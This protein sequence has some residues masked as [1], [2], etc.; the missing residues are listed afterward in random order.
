MGEL[1]LGTAPRTR[2]V[3][4]SIQVHVSRGSASNTRQGTPRYIICAVASKR[5]WQFQVHKI[6]YKCCMPACKSGYQPWYVR[7]ASFTL[8][9]DEALI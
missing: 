8:P 6:P 9:K 5:L 4:Q 3:L 7:A 2:Q 1:V